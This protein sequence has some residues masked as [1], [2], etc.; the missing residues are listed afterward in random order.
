MMLRM[1]TK[2]DQAGAWTANTFR[3]TLTTNLSEKR[4]CVTCSGGVGCND[5]QFAGPGAK[6]HAERHA[7]LDRIGFVWDPQERRWAA[8]FAKLKAFGHGSA[9]RMCPTTSQIYRHHRRDKAVEKEKGQDA[10]LGERGWG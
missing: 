6:L 4:R 3:T 2:Y 7:R 8:M 5:N 9:T 10:R 1:V